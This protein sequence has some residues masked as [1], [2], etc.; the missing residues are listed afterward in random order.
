MP[1][2]PGYVPLR[3]RTT[4][5]LIASIVVAVA[6]IP[7]VVV[8]WRAAGLNAVCYDLWRKPRPG[9]TE[10]ERKQLEDAQ[11]LALHKVEAEHDFAWHEIEK[12]EHE[13]AQGSPDAQRRL[14]EARPRLEARK[15]QAEKALQQAREAYERAVRESERAQRAASA[16]EDE[17]KSRYRGAIGLLY[18]LVIIVD[19]LIAVRFVVWFIWLY[20]AHAN[21]PGLGVTGLAFSP[22]WAVGWWLVPILHIVRPCTVM[23]ELLRASTPASALDR[24][25]SWRETPGVGV[26]VGWWALWLLT[27]FTIAACDCIAFV[28]AFEPPG[29]FVYYDSDPYSLVLTIGVLLHWATAAMTFWL[30]A[31]VARNQDRRHLA[32]GGP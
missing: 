7:V 5:L 31:T 20:R 22:G 26:A 14:E 19:T 12:L 18:V 4:A 29:N 16:E 23:C 15:A 25:T 1:A 24:P 9:I 30:A 2:S 28:R 6:E 10:V 27:G 32:L 17:A 13:R 8:A 11:S 3:G 21:L